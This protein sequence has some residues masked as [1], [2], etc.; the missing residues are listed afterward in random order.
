MAKT[1][2]IP[3]SDAEFKEFSTN[4]AKKVGIHKAELP[5]SEAQVTELDNNSSNFNTK[6]TVHIDAQD[7]AEGATVDKNE[8]R[9][10]LVVNI[11]DVAGAIQADKSVPNNLREILGLPVHDT[12]HS[13]INPEVPE[14]LT[15]IVSLDKII[16][17][18]WKAGLNKPGT[19]YAV[20]AKIGDAAQYSLID[21]T[22]KTKYAHKNQTPGIK[23]NY[24]IY[25]KRADKVS[26]HSNI[27]TVYDD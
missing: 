20:E 15:A 17:L 5:V 10:T 14:D 16:Q 1:G 22:T 3:R 27:A 24:R 8:S 23:I 19:M 7:T 21:M 11:R 9:K 13:V 4:F 2:Y 25:A 26:P 12:T 6:Y 18:D